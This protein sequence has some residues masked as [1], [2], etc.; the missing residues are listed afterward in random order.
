MFKK[1]AQLDNNCTPAKTSVLKEMMAEGFGLPHPWRR[2]MA[3]SQALHL[4]TSL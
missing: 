2:N 4:L 3:F 1:N